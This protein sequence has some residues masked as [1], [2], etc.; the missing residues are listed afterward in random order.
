MHAV[1]NQFVYAAA[2]LFC[3]AICAVYDIRTRRVPNAVTFP[4]IVFGLVLH[5]SLGG[6]RQLAT[7][8]AAGLL[9]GIVF[10]VLHIAGGMG[11]GDVK[12]IT[13]AG[14]ICG[15]SLIGHLLLFS[16]LAGGLM[17]ICLA[18]FRG[19]LKQTILNVGTLTMH[20]KAQGLV[21]HPELN[22]KNAA[23]LRLPYAVP[24]AAGSA[25][26]LCLLLVQR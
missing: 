18:L 11:A 4:A 17:A 1:D 2:S 3:T 14:C 8:A 19:Q 23:T 9:C 10:L 15:I 26:S 21:P 16:A 6:W 22:V 7:A 13:A 5:F 25:L 20:H 12:L 24:I